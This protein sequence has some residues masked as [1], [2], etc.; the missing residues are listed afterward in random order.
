[1]RVP[2]GKRHAL[3]RISVNN[4]H[5]LEICK[6]EIDIM[7]G[8]VLFLVIQIILGTFRS[9]DKD[10]YEY[11]FSVLSSDAHF[12]KCWPPNFMHMLSMENLHS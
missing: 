8:Q 9:E 6:Q 3:K 10:Y 11:K 4:T 1:M 5:D 12:E 7:V 2:S